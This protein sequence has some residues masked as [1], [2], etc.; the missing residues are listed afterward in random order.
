MLP[1]L[2]I[3]PT[4]ALALAAWLLGR[5]GRRRDL[6]P[7]AVNAFLD[8]RRDALTGLAS[9]TAFMETLSTRLRA[10]TPAAL[11]LIDID[12]FTEL[13]ALHG[14]RIADVVLQTLADRLRALS[15]VA[16]G[17]ARVGSDQFAM[18]V[19]CDGLVDGAAA[20]SLAAIRVLQ[21]PVAS[22]AGE[23]EISVSLGVAL[24]PAHAADADAALRCASAALRQVKQAGGGAWRFFNPD[25]D[26]ALLVRAALKEELRAAIADNRIIPYYQPIVDLTDGRIVGVEVLARWPH[27]ERGLLPPDLFI[28]LA[29]ELKLCGQITQQLMRR[30]IADSR[31]WP[32]WLYFAFNVSPGQ[33][34]ELIA[35]VRNPPVWPEGTLDPTR[36]EVEVTESALIEDIDVAREV[37]ALLQAQGTRVV[38]DDFGI[39]FSNFFHLRELPFDRIKMDR[40]FV[41]DSA[42]DPRAQACVRAMLALGHSLGVQ[43]V[44]EGVETAEVAA[45][46]RDLGCSF[47]QGFLYSGAVPAEGVLAMLQGKKERVLS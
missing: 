43:M 6:R 31:K 46:V 45:N 20:A 29:E 38:L 42:H 26:A 9:R 14:H 40:S 2:T 3:A 41:I 34:R 5:S 35:M 10:A 16:G 18:L 4:L 37:M 23:L 8:A 11:L 21:E 33:L 13:N 19:S 15:A 32:A 12:H 47:G 27:P 36:L 22:V 28:P 30:V 1:V 7:A 17:V 44:A 39:G 25:E 24:L